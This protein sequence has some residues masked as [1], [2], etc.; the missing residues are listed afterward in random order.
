MAI[1]SSYSCLENPMDRGAWWATVHGVVKS[2]TCLSDL[3]SLTK[4]ISHSVKK[5]TI[6]RRSLRLPYDSQSVGCSVMS[7][8]C[9]SMGCSLPGSSSKGFSRQQYWRG[10]PFPSPGDL[11]NPEIELGS[12]ELKANSLPSEPLGKP[13]CEM[14]PCL[15]IF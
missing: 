14:M 8:F 5:P 10:L 1:H 6:A 12:L 15:K 11:P 13:Y 4:R 9:D 7:N 3:H 2:Q